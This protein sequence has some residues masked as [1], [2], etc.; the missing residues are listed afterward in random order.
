MKDIFKIAWR[1][2]WRNRRRTMI[3]AASI[4][5]AIFFAICM[6]SFQLGTYDH[7]IKQ[8]IE[9]YT[10]YL[11]VQQKDYPDDP[12]I[13]N[14]FEASPDLLQKINSDP[15]VKVAVP[16]IESF[17][18]ASTGNLSKGVMVSGI[19]P[20][21]ERKM[22][23]PAHKLVRYRLTSPVIALILQDKS[24]PTEKVDKIKSLDNQSFTSKSNLMTDLG[25][26]NEDHVLLDRIC[27]LSSIKGRYLRND[28]HSVLISD[29]LSKYLKANVGDSIVLM[30]QGYHGVSAADIYQICGI[31]KLPSPELDN[32]LVYMPIDRAAELFSL[33]DQVTSIAINLKNTDDMK[34]TQK[35]LAAFDPV[36]LSVRN[37]E[38]MNPTLK[39]QIQGDSE[40]GKVFLAVLYIIIFFGV[41]GT[42]QMMISERWR[43]FG[44]MVAIGMKRGK[45]ALIVAV[46]MLFLGFIGAVSGMLV[47]SPC[48]ILG[49]YYPYTMTG[50]M[51]RMY[52]DMGFTPV[53]PTA[54]FESY[55]F[56]QGVV[57]FL[58]VILASYLP[59]R[60]IMKLNVTQALHGN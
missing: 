58:M 60:S 41:F 6:R 2:L 37:W 9:A 24:I 16:R 1:N 19:S 42:V 52:L 25:L 34:E 48:I 54:L 23:N 18:L 59:I 20:E 27:T 29:L 55:F 44:M 21:Q 4:F 57:I 53:M 13:D 31:V 17:A 43:E 36:N 56:L 10:G 5:F 15:N 33:S 11:Q 35:R 28:D 39:Q 45:L 50:D 22:S 26:T 51:A 7:M 40:S 12:S 3:T 49:H 46:E 32:K 38:E 30:G 14:A 8:I 47:A